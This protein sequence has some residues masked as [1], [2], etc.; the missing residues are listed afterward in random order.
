MSFAL[1]AAADA[2]RHPQ[3]TP[4]A[5]VHAGRSAEL[6]DAC[7]GPLASARVQRVAEPVASPEVPPAEGHNPGEPVLAF[8]SLRPTLP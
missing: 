4:P 8:V 6:V 5:D 2:C 7:A 3:R 1:S